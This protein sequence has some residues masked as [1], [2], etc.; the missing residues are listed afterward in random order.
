MC[1]LPLF[2]TDVNCIDD[3]YPLTWQEITF[4]LEDQARLIETMIYCIV[5]VKMLYSIQEANHLHLVVLRRHFSLTTLWTSLSKDMKKHTKTGICCQHYQCF[6]LPLRCLWTSLTSFCWICCQNILDRFIKSTLSIR[7]L[8]VSCGR[9][10]L[11]S[12][13]VKSSWN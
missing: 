1:Q 11:S 9:H 5:C 13:P 2:F 4:W 10:T 12:W 6:L 7:H 3:L 8:L